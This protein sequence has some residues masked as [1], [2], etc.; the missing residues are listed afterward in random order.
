MN[1]LQK[2]AVPQESVND[3]K[4]LVVNVHVQS[5]DK[6]TKGQLIAELE[7][8]KAIVD[9]FCEADGYANVFCKPGQELSVGKIMFEITDVYIPGA[10]SN[11]PFNTS[12]PNAITT[13]SNIQIHTE[14][15]KQALLLIAELKADKSLFKNDDFVNT[16][17]VKKRLGLEP[18]ESPAQGTVAP[19]KKASLSLPIS[20]ELKFVEH[21][22][23][24]KREIEFLNVVNSTGLVSNLTVEINVSYFDSRVRRYQ[25]IIFST[26]LPLV[27][28]EC[29][30]LL[31]KYPVLNAFYANEGVYFHAEVNV[32]FAVD[33]GK[34]LKVLTIRNT[35]TKSLKEIEHEIYRLIEGYNDN[36]LKKDDTTGATFTITDLFAS[37]TANFLPLVNAQNSTILGIGSLNDEMT[38]FQLSCSFDH[39]VSNGKEI[40]VFLGD[41]KTR[42]EGYLADQEMLELARKREPLTECYKCMRKTDDDMNGQVQFMKVLVKGKEDII[43]SNCLLVW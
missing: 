1:I 9:I 34:G 7:S 36:S 25:E 10:V 43:C 16:R 4:L 27:I 41:L 39:R 12:I 31:A 21:D 8:S 40:S 23:I 14:F 22:I 2:I 33:M 11:V 24:K 17:I 26:P 15:S 5:G 6:V 38:K 37:A 18:T 3:D 35:N 32:G 30:R 13:N 42:L 20:K 28:F 19:I 29:S